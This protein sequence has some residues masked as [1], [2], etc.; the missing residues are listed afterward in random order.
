MR[1]SHAEEKS[2]L[3]IEHAQRRDLA[4]ILDLQRLC[5]RE[6]AERY[7]DFSIPP[8]TQTIDELN[9]EYD[10]SVIL[11]AHERGKIIGSIRG[12]EEK[13]VCLIGRVIVHPDYQNRGIGKALMRGIEEL[14]AQA[15][16]F[17]LFTGA[18]DAKNL[19]FYESMGYKRF[20]EEL[21]G[22][23]MFV[24]LEKKPGETPGE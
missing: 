21:H 20:R 18:N 14:F 16:R 7:G 3:T 11:K 8:L 24:F 15:R 12:R 6:N 22:N 10:E 5:Y 4:D 2:M 17:E 1:I 19:H 23:V 9:A 13:G